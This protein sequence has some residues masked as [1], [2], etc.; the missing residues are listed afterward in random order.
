MF[1]A[2][3]TDKRAA[4]TSPRADKTTALRSERTPPAAAESLTLPFEQASWKDEGEAEGES[5]GAR[6]P[7]PSLTVPDAEEEYTLGTNGEDPA[8]TI[9]G[10][11]ASPP[12]ELLEA[13]APM[14]EAMPAAGKPPPASAPS[15]LALADEE[16]PFVIDIGGPTRRRRQGRES[17]MADSDRG[18]MVA[19]L[20]FAGAV[21]VGY[22]MLA[23]ALFANPGLAEQWFGNVPW[24]GSLRDDRQL[25]RKVAISEVVGTYQRIK[26]GKDVFVISGKAMNTAPVPLQ[27]VQIA[28]RL[29]DTGGRSLDEKVIHC[30]NVISTRVLKDLTP[31]E[32]SVL[33]KLNPPSR[34][35]IEPGASSTFVIVFMD[36]PKAAVSYSAQVVAAQRQA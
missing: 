10:D 34:F 6:A 27:A 3:A 14:P 35:T 11:G 5:E 16:A 23:A 21:T 17:Q 36:P 4:G 25:I 29:F 20:W 30:G 32:L 24:I 1:P 31:R 2:P 19:I 15:P 13:P 28:G 7:E 9:G 18:K 26:D 33:Q 22:A 12:A 8:L